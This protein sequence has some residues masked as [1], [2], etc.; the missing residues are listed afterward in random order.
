MRKVLG[1]PRTAGFEVGAQFAFLTVVAV[2]ERRRSDGFMQDIYTC[3]C[4]CGN[5]LVKSKTGLLKNPDTR[6]RQ[7]AGEQAAATRGG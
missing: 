3:Q 6:C 5:E 2:S 1:R 7:C 4:V